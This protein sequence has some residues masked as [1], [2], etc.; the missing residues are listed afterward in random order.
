M[1]IPYWTFDARTT[2]WYEGERG[3]DEYDTEHYEARDSNGNSVTRTRTVTR[4][5]WYKVNGSVWQNFDDVLVQAG[6]SLPP[7]LM[8][9]LEPWDLHQLVP[10]QDEYMS[11]FQAEAYQ[12]DLGDGFE[13]GKAAYG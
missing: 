7:A 3:E 1:Y 2:T 11:G 6:R 5:H 10:Y 12:V 13:R 9:Q 4:T 8:N